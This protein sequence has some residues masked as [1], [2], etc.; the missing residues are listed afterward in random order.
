[1][2][3]PTRDGR[4]MISAGLLHADGAPKTGSASPP[5]VTIGAVRV[6]NRAANSAA[7]SEPHTP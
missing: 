4:A 6:S 1:M 3:N 7:A 5:H 2:N